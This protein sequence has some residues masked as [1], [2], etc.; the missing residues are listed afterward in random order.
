MARG[1]ES[2]SVEEQIDMAERRRTKAPAK[3]VT[4]AALDA[5]R[6]REGLLLSRTRVVREIETTQNPR[7]K[8]L[9]GKALADLDA[10]ISILNGD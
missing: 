9:L 10:Q 5:I 8:V 1:W 4:A 3:K 2:K 6:K 7:Y